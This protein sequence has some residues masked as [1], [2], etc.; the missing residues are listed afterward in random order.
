MTEERKRQTLQEFC[1]E[2]DRPELLAQWHRTK[3]GGLTPSDVAARS[4]RKV[5]W[6]DEL[7]HEWEQTLY[8]RTIGRCAC[9]VCAGRVVL[10]GFNDL[11]SLAP[12]LAAQ[13]HPTK[14]GALTPQAVRP[15]SSRKVWWLCEK[16]HE[17][18]A[19]ISSRTAGTGCP[20]CANRKI[21]AGVNDFATTHPALA[22]QWH[23][24][25]N[26]ALTPQKISYGYDKKVWWRC[27]KGHEWQASPKTRVRENADCPICSNYVAL[28]GY[29]D[30]ATLYPQI[31]AQWHPTQNGSLTPRDVVGGSNRSV[32]WQCGLG[33]AWRSKIVDRTHGTNG[34]PYCANQKVLPGFND[35]ATIQP[36]I[37]AQWH[38]TLNGT[39]TPQDITAGSS[40]RVWWICQ[41]GHVWRTKVC[42][43]TGPT[44]QTGCPVCAGN[45]KVRGRQEYYAERFG[46]TAADAAARSICVPGGAKSTGRPAETE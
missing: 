46:V 27:E 29:N 23:S 8:N 18:Q 17:W 6:Q 37:A 38:P 9:P 30:L 33:H 36:K 40:R 2:N 32:W 26:G 42:N 4:N 44:K 21:L 16:G 45:V 20:V 11:A 25:K 7:G 24:E 22:A 34:C 35:L 3:N 13:W 28:A 1:L 41:D 19:C 15:A 14:N 5:W 43:R 12:S 31:A 39:L 10:P